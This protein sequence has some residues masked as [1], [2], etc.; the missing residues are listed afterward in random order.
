MEAAC[1]GDAKI[2]EDIYIY[3]T[4][5][6]KTLSS[7][8]QWFDRARD[9]RRSLFVVIDGIFG[10]DP[11]LDSSWEMLLEFIAQYRLE[12]LDLT[13]PIDDVA[14]KLPDHVWPSIEHLRLKAND[15]APPWDAPRQMLFSNF[16]KLSNLR[17][18]TI[19]GSYFLDGMDQIV[20]WHQLRTFEVGAH[21]SCPVPPALC[22]K[23]LRRSRLLEHCRIPLAKEF[24]IST[25]EEIF[26][27][28]M[29]DF[30]VDIYGSAVTTTLQPLVMPNIT[31]FSLRRAAAIPS[32][33]ELSCDMPAL[34]G[35]IQRSGGMRRIRCL[36]ITNSSPVLDI[37]VLLELLPS[38]ESIYIECGHLSD[39]AIKQ[40]S[41]GKLGPLLRN[42]SS[43]YRHDAADEILSMVESR[44]QNAI[45]SPDSEDAP[46]PF[47]TISIPCEARLNKLLYRKRIKLLSEK[48]DVSIRLGIGADEED[49][50]DE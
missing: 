2:V 13:Y 27:A 29:D 50:E 41:S 47:E 39:D 48:C 30:E 42:I 12:E 14:L 17:H 36:R 25:E 34:I 22:L 46:C 32:S 49:E 23:I 24:A 7:A 33:W 8:K 1:I 45:K 31:T 44:Y 15:I 18:L 6:N 5:Y 38:L 26:L 28:N 37:S 9:M 10:P 20:P 11:I 4:E 19:F 3:L 35:I 21:W 40:L 43:G 16:G